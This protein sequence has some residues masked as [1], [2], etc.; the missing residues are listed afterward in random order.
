VGVASLEDQGASTGDDLYAEGRHPHPTPGGFAR[1]LAERGVTAVVVADTALPT[2]EDMI[3]S[4][5][6]VEVYVGEGVS[7]WRFP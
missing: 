2:Y 4:A 1:A 3:R 7:V 6:L 5:G